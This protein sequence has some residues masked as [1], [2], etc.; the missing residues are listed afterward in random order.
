MME[1]SVHRIGTVVRARSV[2]GE[3]QSGPRQLHEARAAPKNAASEALRRRIRGLRQVL[4]QE[5]DGE[6]MVDLYSK[7]IEIY[8]TAATWVDGV[9]GERRWPGGATAAESWPR[10]GLSAPF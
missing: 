7:G 2:T 5:I 1:G 9:C 4:G 6:R 8:P 3:A 10:G